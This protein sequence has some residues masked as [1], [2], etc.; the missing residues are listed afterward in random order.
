MP[1]MLTRKYPYNT[2]IQLNKCLCK[3]ELSRFC[4]SLS[5]FCFINNTFTV[6]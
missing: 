6:K 1:T 5:R 2:K 4:N 3:F